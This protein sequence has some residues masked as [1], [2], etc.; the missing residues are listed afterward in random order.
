MLSWESVFRNTY[1]LQLDDRA[2]KGGWLSYEKETFICKGRKEKKEI[3]RVFNGATCV[4]P[5]NP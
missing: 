3:L 5:F 1:F 2:V 4:E